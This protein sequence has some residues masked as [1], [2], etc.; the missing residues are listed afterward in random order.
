[1][2]VPGNELEGAPF[3]IGL[4][5]F[6][7]GGLTTAGDAESGPGACVAETVLEAGCEEAGG[8]TLALC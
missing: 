4:S 2:A 3:G 6:A 7:T 5:L 1:V 8:A